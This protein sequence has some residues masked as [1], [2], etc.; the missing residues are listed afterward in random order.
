MLMKPVVGSAAADFRCVGLT[1]FSVPGRPGPGR[2]GPAQHPEDLPF[3]RVIGAQQPAYESEPFPFP[4][5]TGLV[6]QCVPLVRLTS[7]SQY[8]T[9]F[10]P[11]PPVRHT[12]AR[13]HTHARR[14][15]HNHARRHARNHARRHA[16]R[17]AGTQARTACLRRRA[18][19][20]TDTR[21][22]AQAQ[23]HA[24]T[25]TNASTRTL[26]HMRSPTPTSPTASMCVHFG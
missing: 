20:D 25:H 5:S 22:Q 12:R 3:L 9:S 6:P 23:T 18:G 2:A 4:T 1:R 10:R 11:R 19:I 13:T 21:A 14:H 17:H 8:L 24:H 7:L 15:A 26:T 16:R